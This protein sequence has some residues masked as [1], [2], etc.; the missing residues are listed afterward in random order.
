MVEI[1]AVLEFGDQLHSVFALI[2]VDDEDPG[3]AHIHPDTVTEK[4]DDH[5]R[6]QIDHNDQTGTPKLHELFGCIGFD[7]VDLQVSLL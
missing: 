4:H 6:H 2:I 5:H 3:M 1:F 7:G